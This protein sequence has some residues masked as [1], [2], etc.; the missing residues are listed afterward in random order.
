MREL[1]YVQAGD[2]QI[3]DVTVED[4]MGPL[5][6]GPLGKYGR[7]R[8]D[9]LMEH[10]EFM[11]NLLWMRGDLP[12][13]I[14]EIQETASRRVEQFMEESLKKNPIPEEMKNADPMGYVGRMENLLAQAEEIVTR[15]LIF[16]EPSVG[17]QRANMRKELLDSI[18]K[19]EPDPEWGL[20]EEDL[21]ELEALSN[22][23]F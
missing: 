5:P 4:L 7:M 2:Y 13:H 17:Q 10:D 23:P 22:L 14:R 6:K 3:P 19:W 11:Y 8:L 12:G 16:T 1:N 18:P 9:H 21:I 15:E 20:T